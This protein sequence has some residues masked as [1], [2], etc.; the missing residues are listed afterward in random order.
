MAP[1]VDSFD[2]DEEEGEA[3]QHDADRPPEAQPA[4]PGVP[5]EPSYFRGHGPREPH[6]CTLLERFADQVGAVTGVFDHAPLVRYLDMYDRVQ[7]S[8]PRICR[9]CHG[10]FRDPRPMTSGRRRVRCPKCRRAR[11]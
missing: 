3:W 1:W 10:E 11:R 5:H 7:G 8:W 4:E 2:D 9:A 6:A